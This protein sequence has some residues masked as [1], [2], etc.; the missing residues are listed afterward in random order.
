M[1]QGGP[2]LLAFLSTI[3]CAAFDV[4]FSS[5]VGVG[6]K[7][8]MLQVFGLTSACISCFKVASCA[9]FVLGRCITVFQPL[10]IFLPI[11]VNVIYRKDMESGVR[12]SWAF[13]YHPLVHC[14]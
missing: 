11:G 3:M 9:G 4:R 13:I 14:V 8:A 2:K 5:V 6:L 12:W 10:V 7:G 1:P